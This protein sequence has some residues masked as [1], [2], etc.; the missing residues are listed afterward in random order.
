MSTLRIKKFFPFSDVWKMFCTLLCACHFF[1]LEKTNMFIC[2]LV[3]NYISQSNT[4]LKP[5]QIKQ[6][7][8]QSC[9]ITKFPR[10]AKTTYNMITAFQTVVIFSFTKHTPFCLLKSENVKI[11]H[12]NN[13]KSYVWMSFSSALVWCSWWHGIHIKFSAFV[14]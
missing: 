1:Y 11:I 13:K 6:L 14:F 3:C 12:K 10:V 2:T 5:C 8:C 7:L 4:D 9:Y